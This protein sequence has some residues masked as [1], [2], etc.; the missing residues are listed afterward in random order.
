MH[1]FLS[2]NSFILLQYIWLSFVAEENCFYKEF[3]RAKPWK[4]HTGIFM[5]ECKSH[6]V[7]VHTHNLVRKLYLQSLTMKNSRSTL[8][9][10]KWAFFMCIGFTCVLAPLQLKLY[11]FTK[12]VRLN[13][14]MIFFS[15]ELFW[16]IRERLLYKES[17][18]CHV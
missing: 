14:T 12:Y 16:N 5:T 8:I 7:R 17:G 10:I 13:M 9:C 15:C 6:M 1:L 3:S 18:C 11:I 4:C 2:K